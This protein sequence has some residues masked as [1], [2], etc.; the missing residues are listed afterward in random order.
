MDVLEGRDVVRI[1]DRHAGRG[2]LLS[3]HFPEFLLAEVLLS[4]AGREW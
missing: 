2:S 1:C 3:R 4:L